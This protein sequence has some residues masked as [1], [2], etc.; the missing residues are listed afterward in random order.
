MDKTGQSDGVVKPGIYFKLTFILQKML[1][2]HTNETLAAK[3]STRV[4]PIERKEGLGA[5]G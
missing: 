1:P 3:N 4:S 2:L 5:G